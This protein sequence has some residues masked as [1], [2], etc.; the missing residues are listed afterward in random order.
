MHF[1]RVT[2]R[3]T[4]PEPTPAQTRTVIVYEEGR[5]AV[6]YQH[7][8]VLALNSGLQTVKIGNYRHMRSRVRSI[9]IVQP[10]ARCNGST[11]NCP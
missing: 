10:H 5:P 7:V 9:E 3:V 11:A 1:P 4:P 2:A 8:P 6:L